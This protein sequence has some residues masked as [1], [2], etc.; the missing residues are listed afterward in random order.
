MLTLP[1]NIYRVSVPSPFPLSWGV[2]LTSTGCGTEQPWGTQRWS[3]AQQHTA[4]CSATPL[5]GSN[6][7][8]S[9]DPIPEVNYEIMCAS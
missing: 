6:Q 4:G 2:W 9:Y 7:K 3:P 1:S 5:L 8:K